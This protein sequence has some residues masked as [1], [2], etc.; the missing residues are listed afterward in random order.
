MFNLTKVA[1]PHIK[2]GSAIINTASINAD[3]PDPTLLA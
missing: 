1:V 2:K 3:D